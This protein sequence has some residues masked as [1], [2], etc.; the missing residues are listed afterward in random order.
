M[1]PTVGFL[2]PTSPEAACRDVRTYC[3]LRGFRTA[4]G[5]VQRPA[6]LVAPGSW[7]APRTL[8]FSST[9]D[10]GEAPKLPII[11]W[12]NAVLPESAYKVNALYLG[13]PG[14][15]GGLLLHARRHGLH[16]Q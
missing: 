5:V 4:D 8:L 12:W 10:S 16:H 6:G 14:Q 3:G 13:E 1:M 9:T 11:A 7:L 2:L 15:H